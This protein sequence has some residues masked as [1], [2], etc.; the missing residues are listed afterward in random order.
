MTFNH[1]TIQLLK[2]IQQFIF[3]HHTLVVVL[4]LLE[5]LFEHKKVVHQFHIKIII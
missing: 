1:V 3:S 2:V 5:L 4:L